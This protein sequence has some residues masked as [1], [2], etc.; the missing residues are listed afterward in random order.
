MDALRGAI[1]LE[2]ARRRFADRLLVG[3]PVVEGLVL[4]Q[5]A[6]RIVVGVVLTLIAEE[7]GRLD[8]RHEDLGMRPQVVVKRGRSRLGGADDQEVGKRHGGSLSGPTAKSG[9]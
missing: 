5:R 7:S 6:H 4:G 2:V 1:D 3:D 8:V 9:V